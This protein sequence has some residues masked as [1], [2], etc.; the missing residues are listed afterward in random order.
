M[1]GI[2]INAN[3]QSGVTNYS[4]NFEMFEKTLR[5][6]ILEG[7]LKIPSRNYTNNTFRGMTTIKLF[8]GYLNN[9]ISF[10]EFIY[11]F[12]H[13][14]AYR[15][16]NE[17]IAYRYKFSKSEKTVIIESFKKFEKQALDYDYIEAL[18]LKNLSA[19]WLRCFTFDFNSLVQN[20][21]ISINRIIY[22]QLTLTENFKSYRNLQ[23]IQLGTTSQKMIEKL[24][25]Q[26]YDKF[27]YQNINN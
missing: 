23:I 21:L 24:E 11:Y 15:F 10:I 9:K 7:G 27:T 8:S 13:H 18:N 4:S 2:I 12:T 26:T 1:I 22:E 17:L 5:S 14:T 25:K 20:I 16:N 3:C 19:E 6:I